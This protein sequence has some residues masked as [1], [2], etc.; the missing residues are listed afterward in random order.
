MCPFNTLRGTKCPAS[1]LLMG[2]QITISLQFVL[3]NNISLLSLSCSFTTSRK[4]RFLPIAY[5]SKN[6]LCSEQLFPSLQ[7]DW[8]FTF[9]KALAPKG[10]SALI[11]LSES[12]PLKAFCRAASQKCLRK[13]KGCYFITLNRVL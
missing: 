3:L 8:E 13:Q 5:K 6:P 7:A 4:I 9:I 11:V 2:W 1:F 12:S 10:Q